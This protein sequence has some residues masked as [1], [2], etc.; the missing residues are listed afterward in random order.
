LSFIRT[1]QKLLVKEIRVTL[2][3]DSADLREGLFHLI[4]MTEGF[5]LAGLFSDCTNVIENVNETMPDVVLMDIDM[6]GMSGI[7]GV[8]LIKNNFPD[9]NILMLTVF[10]DDDK[11]FEALRA[12]ASGYLLKKTYPAKYWMLYKKCSVAALQ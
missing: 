1:T 12:G 10:E 5:T 2:F 8:R 3:D 11:I 6:P 4:N 9:I 7:E